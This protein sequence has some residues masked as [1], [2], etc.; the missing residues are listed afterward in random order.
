MRLR[1]NLL[2]HEYNQSDSNWPSCSAH[3][4]QV[5][6]LPRGFGPEVTEAADTQKMLGAQQRT[7]SM[8]KSTVL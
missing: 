8:Y 6:P 5:P 3:A 1:V 4:P 7:Y 2:L